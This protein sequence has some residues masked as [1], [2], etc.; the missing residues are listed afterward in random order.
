[1][2]EK[3]LKE[4]NQGYQGSLENFLEKG[5]S[6]FANFSEKIEELSIQEISKFTELPD[7]VEASADFFPIVIKSGESCFCIDG[8]E[9]VENAKN[10]QQTQIFCRVF[11]VHK[12]SDVELAI[13]K[14]AIR[15][16]PLAGRALYS[17]IVRNIKIL[18]NFIMQSKENIKVYSHGGDRKSDSFTN[19]R[20]ENIRLILMERFA[21]KRSTIN[22]YI[23]HGSYLTLEALEK[24]VEGKADKEFFEKVNNAKLQIIKEL[25]SKNFSADEITQVVSKKIIEFFNN[26]ENLEDLLKKRASNDDGKSEKSEPVKK[27]KFLEEPT[28]E[29]WTGNDASSIVKL[30]EE[31]IREKAAAICQRMGAR[32][33]DFSTNF[34]LIKEAVIGDVKELLSLINCMSKEESVCLN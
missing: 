33:Q 5:K 6:E 30:C 25:K 19:N 8:W 21:K 26:R 12:I 10:A 9:K 13:R 7:Y 28:L 22:Q 17:E 20:E 23:S 2:E 3:I 31:E 15:M 4:E 14:I 16:V 29:Y 18:I 24:L 11:Y 34:S 1:M 27:E 32:F